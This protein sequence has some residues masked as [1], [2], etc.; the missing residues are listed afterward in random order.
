VGGR[1]RIKYSGKSTGIVWISCF[2]LLQVANGGNTANQ[3]LLRLDIKGTPR[4]IHYTKE[5]YNADSQFWSMCEDD[6]G[7]LYFGNNDGILIFDGERWQLIKLPNGSTVRSLKYASDG[8]V[9]VG[10]YNDLGRIVKNELGHYQFLS[11]KELL[12]PEDRNFEDIWQI[13]EAQGHIIFRSFKVLIA[14]VDNKAITLPA[15]QLFTYS[16]VINDRLYIVDRKILKAVNLRTLEIEDIIQGKWLNEEDLISL[17]PGKND[18]EHIAFTKQ[19]S[20][21]QVFPGQKRAVF[22]QKHLPANSID[23]VFCALKSR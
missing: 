9:Y 16:N 7:I 8:Q 13:H 10:G 21:F 12:R 14:V 2:C 23:Q 18:E 5:D 22:F 11:M 1:M 17:L 15:D 20:S 19:G 3:D 6:E 4:V